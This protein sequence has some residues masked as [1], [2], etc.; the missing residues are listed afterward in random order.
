MNRNLFLL[1]LLY[2]LSCSDKIMIEY[3]SVNNKGM[4][5][6]VY[7]FKSWGTYSHPVRPIDP[8][9]YEDA[10]RREGFCRA[11][12]C[13]TAQGKLFV[14]FEG[15]QNKAEIT[16]LSKKIQ[17]DNMHFYALPADNQTIGPEISAE[18]TLQKKQFLVAF[19]D[20]SDYLVKLTQHGYN[21]EYKC[22]QSGALKQVIITSIDGR[23]N[24][25]NY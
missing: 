16:N 21:Y 1:F 15:L 20:D 6:K 19:P 11:W 17:D 18:E 14:Y 8:M 22:D 12:M 7:F 4:P 9:T 13:N 2:L 5:C 23:V 10:L 3:I 25:L 24:T